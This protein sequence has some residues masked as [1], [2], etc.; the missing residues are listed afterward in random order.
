MFEFR[1][2]GLDDASA[3][4]RNVKMEP[5]QEALIKDLA[6]LVAPKI[7][8]DPFPCRGFWLMAT[9]AWQIEHETTADQ[10]ASMAPR[11][12]LKA[13]LGI[14]E[15]FRR[16]VGEQLHQ[17]EQR[18]KLEGVLDDAFKLYLEKYNRR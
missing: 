17:P 2:G 3:E 5:R 7:G 9:R 4:Y 12:R 6:A 16:I 8:M 14:A 11:D 1:P 13:A 10:I 18:A 15:H